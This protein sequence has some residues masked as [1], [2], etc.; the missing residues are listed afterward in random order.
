MSNYQQKRSPGKDTEVPAT[1]SLSVFPK[2]FAPDAREGWG[3]L[4]TRH[5]ISARRQRRFRTADA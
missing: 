4:A 1:T 2:V 3:R 5:G